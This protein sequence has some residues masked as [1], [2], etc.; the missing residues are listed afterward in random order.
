MTEAFDQSEYFGVVFRFENVKQTGV[1]SNMR[2]R[3][4]VKRKLDTADDCSQ[5]SSSVKQESAA[6]RPIGL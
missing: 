6:C 1:C 5:F 2:S 3:T 4:A